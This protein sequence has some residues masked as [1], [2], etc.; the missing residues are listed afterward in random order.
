MLFLLLG[1]GIILITVVAV[2]AYFILY[3]LRRSKGE[4]PFKKD[5]RRANEGVERDMEK[6][7][8]FL[9]KI[10]KRDRVPED[11]EVIIIGSGIGGLAAA[12]LL[13]KAGKKVAV[14]E[15]HTTAG[16]CCH[17]F[18]Q[19]GFE[20]DS[21]IH[22]V[23]YSPTSISLFMLDQLTE[24]QMEWEHLHDTYDM[25]VVNKE[26]F[27]FCSGR[28]N[29][30]KM[31]DERFPDS[32]EEL[33]SYFHQITRVRKTE[34]AL[35]LVK[36]FPMWFMKLIVAT[37][38]IK[39]M[40]GEFFELAQTSVAEV[41]NRT[42]TDPKLRSVLMYQYGDYG[43]PPSEASFAMHGS[44]VE[45][46]IQGALY[47]KG[48]S[49][50]VTIAL[51]KTLQR[52]GNGVVL[53]KG[54]VR[55]VEIENGQCKGVIM[56]RDD[57]FIPCKTVLSDAGLFNTFEHLVPSLKPHLSSYPLKDMRQGFSSMCLFVG[58]NGS[59][60]ELNV[61]ATNYWLMKSSNIEKDIEEFLKKTPEELL[62]GDW[63]LPVCFIS[64]PSTKDSIARERHPNKTTC[65]V[66][67]LSAFDWFTEWSEEGI[68]KRGTE[69]EA[70]KGIFSDKMWKCVLK[71]FPQLEDK[72]EHM[73][74]ASPLTNKYFLNTQKGEI[75]GLDH[76]IQRFSPMSL[77][78]LRSPTP[79]KG[80]YL[81]GQDV[82]TCGFSGALY[83]ALLASCE[84]LQ[85]NVLTD[86][87]KLKKSVESAQTSAEE[88]KNQ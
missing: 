44:L 4:N 35:F 12:V 2:A 58:L 47:P 74:A 48:G 62:T 65:T 60:E 61:Q 32:K 17:T 56:D 45:H 16:G 73:D 76:T 10:Y 64:F 70:L 69:Y 19:K 80:L 57:A 46:Y 82:V 88:K 81:T 30:R 33:D 1:G 7:D 13:A 63:E 54:R 50:E 18:F 84:V 29:L 28:E 25:A 77:A 11:T 49:S 52:T 59:A 36:L 85:R 27:H 8:Q 38:I 40:F 68:H 6:R 53:V 42:I 79:I 78:S 24:G 5:V 83:G 72:V 41:V 15:Q 14:L 55:S 75:Y 39:F 51:I 67:A 9:K 37:G 26:E 20:F 3:P 71:Q 87:M 31:L 66:V 86:I 22:Y 21:G 34:M 43:C 23:G